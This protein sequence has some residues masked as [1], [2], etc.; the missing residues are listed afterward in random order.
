MRNV[1]LKGI[2]NKPLKGN[3]VKKVGDALVGVTGKVTSV[4]T[5]GLVKAGGIIKSG[6][7][8]GF[9]SYIGTKGI[10][11][12]SLPSNLHLHKHAGG[13]TREQ[14]IKAVENKPHQE[15][16]GV[17]KNMVKNIGDRIEE[18]EEHD[19]TYGEGG[20]KFSNIRTA[21]VTK[22]IPGSGFAGTGVGYAESFA[23]L[24]PAQKIEYNTPDI[25]SYTK[26]V[27]D[28]NK[29]K[30]G[31]KSKEKII[32]TREDTTETVSTFNPDTF[33]WARFT[34]R[35]NTGNP[36]PEAKDTTFTSKQMKEAYHKAGGY[37]NFMKKIK[38]M[39][40]WMVHTGKRT[41][42]SSTSTTRFGKTAFV[43]RK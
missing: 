20:K 27:I 31:T 14:A 5:S 18:A 35:L 22:K 11:L 10:N 4:F 2:Y 25:K 42:G 24:T 32:Q 23:T 13:I 9:K 30:Y 19:W 7:T 15:K 29:L 6:I 17:L 21:E 16:S 41:P 1:P 3:I 12:T 36:D 39:Y 34:A 43:T 33:D 37:K 8:K 40:K 38:N 26:Y 28:F